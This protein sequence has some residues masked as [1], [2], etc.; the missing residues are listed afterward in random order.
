MNGRNQTSET[1][2]ERTQDESTEL[3]GID[4]LMEQLAGSAV[5]DPEVVAQAWQRAS[6]RVQEQV[7]T[8][9]TM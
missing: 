1:E 2:I 3:D 5:P 9:S 6:P 8:D 4:V 7:M